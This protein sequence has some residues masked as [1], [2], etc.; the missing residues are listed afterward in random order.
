[1]TSISKFFISA[2]YLFSTACSSLPSIISIDAGVSLPSAAELVQNGL[3][4]IGGEASLWKLH[5][6]TYHIPRYMSPISYL[7]EILSDC[8]SIYRTQSLMQ[9]N[10]LVKI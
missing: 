3:D 7:L 4:A 1:M 9:N 2:I 6:V 8:D 10:D 5:G